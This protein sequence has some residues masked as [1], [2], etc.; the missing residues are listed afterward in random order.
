MFF[1]CIYRYDHDF[2]L[3]GLLIQGITSVDFQMLNTLCIQF[4]LC[5]FS[6]MNPSGAYFQLTHES[7][8]FFLFIGILNIFFYEVKIC[9]VDYSIRFLL[10]NYDFFYIIYNPSSVAYVTDN[11]S[12]VLLFHI[13]GTKDFYILCKP[14]IS[15]SHCNECCFRG[16][17][18]C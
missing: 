15:L 10:L 4:S 11:V 16:E 17:G 12:Y 9:L 18:L 6:L 8:H 1:F 7:E 2:S 13:F 5:L 14:N 3:P